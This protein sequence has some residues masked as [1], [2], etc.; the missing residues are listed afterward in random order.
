MTTATYDHLPS[1]S[2]GG[3]ASWLFSV[4]HKRVG[5]LYLVGSMAAFT[6]AALMALGIRLEQYAPGESGLVNYFVGDFSKSMS[7]PDAYNAMLTFHGAVMILGFV[8][9]GLTGF[10]TN[11]LVPIMI[12][13]KDVAFPGSTPS[14]S[15]CTCA[16]LSWRSCSSSS[17]TNW[18]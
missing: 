3:I 5:I 17:R 14:A 9:P 12:G 2:G 15:G 13:A 4:D 7:T 8:I 16:A 6:L 18:T 11:Y 1:R 10:A